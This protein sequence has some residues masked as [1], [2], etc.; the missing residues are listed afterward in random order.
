MKSFGIFFR[1]GGKNVF[2]VGHIVVQA[3][4]PREATEKVYN[5]F[6][7]LS[8]LNVFSVMPVKNGKTVLIFKS[9]KALNFLMEHGYIYTIR[10]KK[11]AGEVWITDRRGGKKIADGFIVYVGEVNQLLPDND[12]WV[13]Q[14]ACALEKLEKFVQ[15]SGFDSIEE[16]INAVKELHGGELPDRMYLHYVKLIEGKRA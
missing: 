5:M 9:E 8:N 10:T 3:E 14:G 6:S 16:W 12:W 1:F 2:G 4:S 11:R 13:T 15:H 7:D